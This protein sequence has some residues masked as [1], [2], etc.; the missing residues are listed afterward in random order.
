MIKS[1][2]TPVHHPGGR[3]GEGRV[4]PH[5]SEVEPVVLRVVEVSK[6]SSEPQS[7]P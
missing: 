5:L 3:G 7:G 6:S 1:A 2:S 4:A